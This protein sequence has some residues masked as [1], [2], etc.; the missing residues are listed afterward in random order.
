MLFGFLHWEADLRLYARLRKLPEMKFRNQFGWQLTRFLRFQTDTR[1]V[2]DPGIS[3]KI[4]L[5]NRLLLGFSPTL[6][7]VK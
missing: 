6:R 7:S 5:E 2:Y 1:L 3:S 4:Q